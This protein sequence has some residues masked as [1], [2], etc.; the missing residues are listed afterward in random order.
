MLEQPLSGCL[1]DVGA[2]A[3]VLHCD[4][5]LCSPR[6]ESTLAFAIDCVSGS[7]MERTQ[8]WPHVFFK[9]R[10]PPVVTRPA[11]TVYL[12]VDIRREPSFLLRRYTALVKPLQ[13][14]I[15]LFAWWGIEQRV[16]PLT[17]HMLSR[18]SSTPTEDAS[19]THMVSLEHEGQ[20]NAE[21]K[22]PQ[23]LRNPCANKGRR[24]QGVGQGGGGNHNRGHRRRL[25]AI[26]NRC[27]RSTANVAIR[28]TLFR[29]NATHLFAQNVH[30]RP[31]ATVTMM[32]STTK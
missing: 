9:D 15:K 24:V 16:Q 10:H 17:K 26:P 7:L 14:Q 2:S 12:K 13:I 6:S 8:D 22:D 29:P 18:D 25:W 28:E 3:H 20:E 30:N 23:G 21:A 27:S 5:G 4:C 19:S 31:L 1:W 11:H 32:P